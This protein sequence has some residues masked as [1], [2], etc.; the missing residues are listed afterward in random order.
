MTSQAIAIKEA[1]TE[2]PVMDLIRERWSARSFSEKEMPQEILNTILEAASWAPSSNNEQPWFFYP[3]YK[4]TGRFNIL[5]ESLMPGN[6]PWAKNAAA[7][8]V[9][10]ARTEFAASG[11]PNTYADHDLGLANGFLVLQAR[12]L[13]VFCHIMAGFDKSKISTGLE[14]TEIQ[15]PMCIIALGYLDDAEKLEEPFKTRE[16]TGRSRLPL[17]EIL[18]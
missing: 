9:T 10:I 17:S 1:Q 7:L 8:V 12:K 6:Y 11:K 3:A 14:L 13:D 4:G 15:K 2:F 5:L 16:V 18:L